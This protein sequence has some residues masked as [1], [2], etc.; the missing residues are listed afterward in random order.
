[1]KKEDAIRKQLKELYRLL[2]LGVALL[3][4]YVGIFIYQGIMNPSFLHANSS[5]SAIA[6]IPVE[7]NRDSIENGIHLRTG[8]INAEGLMTVVNNCTNCHSSKLIT[9]NKMSAERWN[10]TIK[11]MQETQNLWELGSNQDVIVT[12]LVTN[13]PPTKKGRRMVLQNIDWYELED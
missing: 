8:L 6:T 2:Y 7:K 3:L 10:E 13:Y 11:W 12:Y 5:N 9:Q 1:M 4:L